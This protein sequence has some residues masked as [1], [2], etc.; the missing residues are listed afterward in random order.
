MGLN[1]HNALQ[2]GKIELITEQVNFG[3]PLITK[4]KTTKLINENDIDVLVGL[5]NSEVCTH[6]SSTIQNSK[7]PFI[8]ANAGENHPVPEI[9][10]NQY[11][12]LNHL[13]L[14][15]S[16]Y[17]LGELMVKNAGKKALIVTSFYDSGYD[18]LFSFRLGVEKAGGEVVD[19]LVEQAGDTDFNQKVFEKIENEKPDF[20]FVFMNGKPAVDLLNFYGL[21]GR[22]TPVAV[23]QFILDENTLHEL[24]NTDSPL[25]SV[26]SWN[27][28]VSNEKNKIFGREFEKDNRL[29]PDG[30]ALLGYETGLQIYKALSEMSPGFTHE[31]FISSLFSVQID[32]PRG[33]LSFEKE[34]GI[35]D[36]PLYT[37]ECNKVAGS[38]ELKNKITGQIEPLNSTHEDF[39]VLDTDLRS[40]WFN[41]YLF[42]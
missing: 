10:N 31:E 21:S 36:V 5:L 32:S 15:Q 35:L 18:A 37:L 6:I 38:Y 40:G 17:R 23:S 29:K 22:K 14:Y 34:T 20:V 1:Q 26:T 3:T 27:N 33:K 11:I 7:T 8:L 16:N 25:F 9:R 41:P 28:A 30:F 42:V 12:F 4:E 24:G 19:T 2:K 39:A 13:A